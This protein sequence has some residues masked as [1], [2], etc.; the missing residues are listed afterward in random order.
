MYTVCLYSSTPTGAKHT[1]T[2]LPLTLHPSLSLYPFIHFSTENLLFQTFLLLHSMLISYA[3]MRPVVCRSHGVQRNKWASQHKQH[4]ESRITLSSWNC[5]A[6]K[7]LTLKKH[8]WLQA[9]VVL[10]NSHMSG[11]NYELRS[12]SKTERTEWSELRIWKVVWQT[13][14][15][16]FW[17]NGSPL[18]NQNK[19]VRMKT[20]DIWNS[21][22]ENK[23]D[24]NFIRNFLCEKM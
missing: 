3:A 24:Q 9:P 1:S 8:Q 20:K 6:R 16:G 14:R 5:L 23:V 22:R 18:K 2:F 15:K 19:T 11:S 10:I 12:L 4:P 21:N 17:H 7:L 13:V